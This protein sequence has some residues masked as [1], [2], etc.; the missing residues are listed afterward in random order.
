MSTY[1]GA[2]APSGPHYA[3]PLYG[4]Q[5]RASV[6]LYAPYGQYGPSSMPVSPYGGYAPPTTPR[7]PGASRRLRLVIVGVV[8]AVIMALAFAGAGIASLSSHGGSVLFKDALLTDT[9]HWPSDAS[10]T[11]QSDGYHIADGHICY[12]SVGAF[13]DATFSVRLRQVSSAGADGYSGIAL[14]RVSKGNLYTFGVTPAGE[15][16]FVKTVN[17]TTTVVAGPRS[18]D[19]VHTG[20]NTSNT[21]EVRASGAHFD[22]F[23]NGTQVGTADDSTFAA[24]LCGLFADP[25]IESAFTEFQVSR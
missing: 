6:P 20:L 24:G 1:G 12:A 7:A 18:S 25:G 21:L 4:Q 10:C 5:M 15:W 19:A 23:V 11:F 16:A 14:R 22:L 9:G 2:G 17:D 13:G 8:V 3:Q